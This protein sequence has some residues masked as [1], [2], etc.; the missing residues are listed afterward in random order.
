MRP[1][2]GWLRVS[3]TEWQR[4][5]SKVPAG[6]SRSYTLPTR[7]STFLDLVLGGVALHVGELLLAR[8]DADHV[9]DPL[10]QTECDRPST[11]ADIEHMEI[12]VQVREEKV[13]VVCR[14][15][16]LEGC[17]EGRAHALCPTFGV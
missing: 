11:A 17:L 12:G 15:S 3:I 14:V 10:R 8:I 13:S 7:N 2:S 6:K 9:S 16:D 4:Q 1:S 5:A